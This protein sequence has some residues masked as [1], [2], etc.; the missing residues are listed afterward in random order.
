[1]DVARFRVVWLSHVFV[2]VPV[3]AFLHSVL[4][5]AADPSTGAH[6]SD[7]LLFPLHF[8]LGVLVGS[9][10]LV[11]AFTCQAM[12]YQGLVLCRTPVPLV[13]VGCGVFQA[14]LVF[15]W[16]G[17]VGI[18]PS[19]AGRFCLTTPMIFAGFIAGGV[20]SF[21]AAVIAKRHKVNVG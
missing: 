14:S 20:A 19:L 1:M 10:I 8:I 13:V 5:F 12:L 2:G 17:L 21:S 4:Q 11:P 9:V 18:E 3:A 7:L 16:A 15:L 6:V